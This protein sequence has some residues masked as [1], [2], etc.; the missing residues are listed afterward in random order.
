MLVVVVGDCMCGCRCG[1]DRCCRGG[2]FDIGGS[3]GCVGRGGGS[4]VMSGGNRDCDDCS[5]FGPISV[6][7]ASS[8][9]SPLSDSFAS[10]CPS[11][12]ASLRRLPSLSLRA[13]HVTRV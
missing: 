10:L 6:G 12:T 9:T 1:G 11:G 4:G 5:L 8:G 13:I 2:G 3:R 7:D